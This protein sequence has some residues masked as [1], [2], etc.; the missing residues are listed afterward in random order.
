MLKSS[1]GSSKVSYKGNPWV[2]IDNGKNPMERG[3]DKAP[4]FRILTI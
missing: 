3:V 4:S 1:K 2:I